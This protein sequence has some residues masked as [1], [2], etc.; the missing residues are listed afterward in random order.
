MD[1]PPKVVKVF[2]VTLPLKVTAPVDPAVASCKLKI[3]LL[4]LTEPPKVMAP[5]PLFKEGEAP[6]VSASL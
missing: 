2:K 4:P 3:W 1:E 6:K 5:L